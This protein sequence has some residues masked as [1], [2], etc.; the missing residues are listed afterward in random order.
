MAQTQEQL[1][2][3]VKN[4]EESL[5]RTQEQFERRVKNLGES[6]QRAVDGEITALAYAF[7]LE[8]RVQ[9]LYEQLREAENKNAALQ[10]A[11]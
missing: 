2:R 11:S 10:E 7:S 4:L 6:L 9:A 5:Q 8:K 1:E 3:N